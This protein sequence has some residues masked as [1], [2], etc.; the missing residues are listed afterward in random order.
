MS[1]WKL[2]DNWSAE[3]TGLTVEQL[4]ERRDFASRR[5]QHAGARGM[6]RNPK[7]AR[8]WR[9]KLQA[10]ETELLRRAAEES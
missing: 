7:A 1:R 8:D 3:L 5:A 10:V 4:P 9:T 6:G 2:Y